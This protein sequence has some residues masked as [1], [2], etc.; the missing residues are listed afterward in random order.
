MKF[1]I[2]K[3]IALGTIAIS[4]ALSSSNNNNVT[5]IN[6]KIQKRDIKNTCQFTLPDY[7]VLESF[8]IGDLFFEACNDALVIPCES[9][10]FD[11]SFGMDQINNAYVYISDVDG[12][13]VNTGIIIE[14][15]NYGGEIVVNLANVESPLSDMIYPS[16]DTFNIKITSNENGISVYVDTIFK[17]SLSNEVL[18]YQSTFNKGPKNIYL[19]GTEQ[20]MIISD[21]QITCNNRDNACVESS[22]E[23]SSE[24]SAESSSES[25]AESSSESSA[26]S[27][28]ESS[29]E[30]SSE[31]SAESSS[32]SSA[33]SSSESSAES[34][35]ESSAES[36]SESSAESSSESS[37]ESS[38]ESSA[39]SSSESSADSSSESSSVS[40]TEYSTGSSAE[41]Y[42]E[43]SAESSS[44][45][46]TESLEVV[47]KSEVGDVLNLS[48]S[49]N[50]PVPLYD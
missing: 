17:I 35:S 38:S 33:E 40:S 20:G 29:A 48:G 19:G 15:L 4:S 23:S 5:S 12:P 8:N 14:L 39:E 28:S 22:T 6:T 49:N 3:F 34:S 21:I 41:S 31:S 18:K 11:V 25:S 10:F 47:C 44:E 42:S 45:T 24:S 36:S 13:F 37:A 43:S 16:S 2:K 30:S 50:S 26:E 7:Q 9:Y 27:S 46:N 32:E 1:S